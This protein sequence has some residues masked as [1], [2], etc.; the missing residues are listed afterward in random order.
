MLPVLAAEGPR[1]SHLLARKRPPWSLTVLLSSHGTKLS[2]KNEFSLLKPPSNDSQSGPTPV[3]SPWFHSTQH[4]IQEAGGGGPGAL[5]PIART[6]QDH[7]Q[8]GRWIGWLSSPQ[9]RMV[10]QATKWITVIRKSG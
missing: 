10:T 4:S 7:E 2:A 6:T 8:H 9:A 3:L 1:E 5:V